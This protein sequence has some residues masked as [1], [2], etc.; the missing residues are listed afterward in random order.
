MFMLFTPHDNKVTAPV[1]VV[2][3]NLTVV[4]FRRLGDEKELALL[5]KQTLDIDKYNSSYKIITRQF[6][7][8]YN[9]QLHSVFAHTCCRSRNTIVKC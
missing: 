8:Q 3:N 9:F 6:S 2:H 4:N 1:Y 5:I 7:L